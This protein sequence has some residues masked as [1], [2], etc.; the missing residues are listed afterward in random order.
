MAGTLEVGRRADFVVLAEDPRI[1]DPTTIP[2]IEV[3]AT[4]IG[5]EVVYRGD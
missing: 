4:V 2:Y 5:G 3:L 1:V